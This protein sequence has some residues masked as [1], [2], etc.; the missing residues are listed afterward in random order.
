MTQEQGNIQFNKVKV[1][2][3]KLVKIILLTHCKTRQEV[4]LQGSITYKLCY[5]KLSLRTSV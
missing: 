3:F 2:N 1:E 4:F 5:L